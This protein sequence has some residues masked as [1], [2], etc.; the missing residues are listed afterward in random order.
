MINPGH[1]KPRISTH[2]PA[3]LVSTGVAV[4]GAACGLIWLPLRALEADG[5]VG[6]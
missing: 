2:R 1:D 6:G 4:C 5:P 3:L